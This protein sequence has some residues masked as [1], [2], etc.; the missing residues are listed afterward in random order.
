[1][2]APLLQ[3]R[4]LV[5]EFASHGGPVRVVDGVDLDVAPGE[6]LAVVGASGSGKTVSMLAVLGLL[7]PRPPSVAR[8]CWAAATCCN[9]RHGSAGRCSAVRSA[10]SS[11]TP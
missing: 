11:R 1:M 2:T 9:C 3:V 7:P 4:G 10:R 5:V 8:R 6:T